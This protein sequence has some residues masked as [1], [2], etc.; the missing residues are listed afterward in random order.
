MT[1]AMI[2]GAGFGFVLLAQFARWIFVMPI[3][4]FHELAPGSASGL[5]ASSPTRP[6]AGRASIPGACCRWSRC[7][8]Q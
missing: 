1:A 7:S 5:V 8:W 2:A 6:L 3:A 4:M